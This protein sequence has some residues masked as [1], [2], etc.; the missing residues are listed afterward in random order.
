MTPYEFLCHLLA[1]EFGVKP[2]AIS[3][4]STPASLGLDSLST[5]E[6]IHGLE[7]EFGIVLTNEQADFSTLGEAAALVDS[8]IQ[9]QQ[10]QA[11][12]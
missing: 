4:E 8:L 3:P 10:T 11:G 7:D 12:T 9:A 2:E 6:L 1:L 5:L